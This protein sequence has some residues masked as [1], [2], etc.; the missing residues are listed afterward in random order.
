MRPSAV[1]RLREP[2]VATTSPRSASADRASG[3]AK[4][5]SRVVA[6]TT[7]S[8]HFSSSAALPAW[9]RSTTSA[10]RG[11]NLTVSWRRMS[12]A[13]PLA[14]PSARSC[15][16]VVI[17]GKVPANDQH[18]RREDHATHRCGAN[19]PTERNCVRSDHGR[20]IPIG[21]VLG[22]CRSVRRAGQDSS[23]RAPEMTAATSPG[24][25][26]MTRWGASSSTTLRR[27]ARW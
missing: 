6:V 15:S 23:A 20:E 24:W 13:C 5:S 9:T 25:V 19:G 2:N 11:P 21:G 18:A 27:P 8:A 7:R 14:W 26:C 22:R 16:A 4:N 10:A 17:F 12:L 1:G 3:Q